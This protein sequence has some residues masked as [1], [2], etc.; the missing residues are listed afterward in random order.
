M[1]SSLWIF[2][3]SLGY[4]DYDA[5]NATIKEYLRKRD[6]SIDKLPFW[7]LTMRLIR[8]PNLL[9]TTCLLLLVLP[10]ATAI[11]PSFGGNAVIVNA[12]G[13]SDL[14]KIMIVPITSDYRVSQLSISSPS[15]D[16]RLPKTMAEPA[17]PSSKSAL[18]EI[19]VNTFPAGAQPD[20]SVAIDRNGTTCNRVSFAVTLVS[21]PSYRTLPGDQ[22][23]RVRV[24]SDISGAIEAVGEV[25]LKVPAS[26]GSTSVVISIPV[27]PTVSSTSLS[28]NIYV[29]VDPADEIPET[30]E[31]NNIAAVLGICQG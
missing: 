23:V 15:M 22:V 17:F 21:N 9:S 3:L 16:Q 25:L 31:A 6:I 26:G 10:L 1:A 12:A 14:E 13:L 11:S 27:P 8:M 24:L 29:A 28:D 20:L 18:P 4:Q 2:D 7:V 5:L 19:A 30:N